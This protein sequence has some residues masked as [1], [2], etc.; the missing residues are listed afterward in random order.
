MAE[1]G[2]PT[3]LTKETLENIKQGILDG[4]TLKEIAEHSKINEG[5]LYQWHSKNYSSLAD[6]VEGWKRDRKVNLA[7]SNLE[8]MLTMSTVNTKEIGDQLIREIDTGLVRVKADMTKFTL[9]TL[10]KETYSK[11]SEMTGAEGKDLFVGLTEEQ[12]KKLD[13]LL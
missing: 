9:E 6:K 12:K 10:A 11:R 2:R 4:K 5:T 3:E 13:N 1:A 7:T 8:E